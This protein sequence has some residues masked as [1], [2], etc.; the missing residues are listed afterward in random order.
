MQQFMAY[1]LQTINFFFIYAIHINVF[2]V[3]NSDVAFVIVFYNVCIV[4][5]V[6][7]I[8]IDVQR[9]T[10]TYTEI[11]LNEMKLFFEWESSNLFALKTIY[12]FP[13]YVEVNQTDTHFAHNART[14]HETQTR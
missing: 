6:H 13:V 12:R 3:L 8:D 1:N 10:Y 2:I 5:V 7:W 11:E 14:Y 9:K 4:D